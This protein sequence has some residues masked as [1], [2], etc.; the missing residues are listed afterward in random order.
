[1]N[2][3]L[4]NEQKKHFRTIGHHLK[5]VVI[6]AEGGLSAGVLAELDRALTD[7]E[8]IKVQLRLSERE[9][10]RALIDELCH[11]G[12]CQLIQVIG[13]IALVYRKNPKANKQLSNIHRHSF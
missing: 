4:S 2:M 12:N 3:S 7:H 8:L 13:K 11:G 6:I 9:E 5:P 1:M 10:R